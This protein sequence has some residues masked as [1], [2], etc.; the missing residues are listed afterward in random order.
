MTLF[1]RV[2]QKLFLGIVLSGIFVMPILAAP[3]DS[4]DDG[5]PDAKDKYPI[6]A[7]KVVDISSI[8]STLN[9]ISITA[10]LSLKMWVLASSNAV[11]MNANNKVSVWYDFSG[12]RNHV[13]AAVADQISLMPT[14]NAAGMNTRPSIQFDGVA[15]KLNFNGSILVGKD[16]TIFVVEKRGDSNKGFFMTGNPSDYSSSGSADHSNKSLNLGYTDANNFAF[17]QFGSNDWGITNSDY[18]SGN[19]IIHGLKFSKTFGKSYMSVFSTG[20]FSQFSNMGQVTALSQYRDANLGSFTDTSYSA[21]GVDWWWYNGW[22]SYYDISQLDGWWSSGYPIRWYYN[23]SST[24]TYY[25]GSISEILVFDQALDLS[26][27]QK[28]M[29]YLS[30]QW[31]IQLTDSDFDGVPDSQDA[32][33][34]DPTKVVNMSTYAPTLNLLSEGAKSNLVLWLDATS[35]AI[36]KNA[37]NNITRW[38]DYSGGAHFAEQLTPD[39]MPTLNT[40]AI[41]GKPGI[42]FDGTDDFLKSSGFLIST[43]NLTYFIV[44]KRV[45]V[46]GETSLFSA[47]SG[48]ADDGDANSLIGFYEGGSGAYL[49]P[50]RAA[51]QSSISPHPGDNV[52]F[53]ASSI[54]DGSNNI[55]YLNGSAY[56]PVASSG[57]MNLSSF[58]IGGRYWSGSIQVPYNGYIGEVL[59]FSSTLSTQ[60]R[61]LVDQYLGI[62]WGISMDTD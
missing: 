42:Y 36:T 59:V 55:S 14:Y 49:A 24:T 8:S 17:N 32:F 33:P 34:S 27:Q 11:S 46:R 50:Y 41:N 7:T 31:G 15:N 5:V 51:L 39:N 44:A 62:K 37:N 22:G 21:Y 30:S 4:D 26:D 12:N 38:Y 10:K 20:K 1:S 53:V 60:D 48:S 9:T 23:T 61:Y 13:S 45:A 29:Q 58:Y 6:D 57:L 28:V 54:F 2:V 3:G 18:S 56:A 40:Q 19:T 25:N 52:P 47:V 35:N 43:K 16:Y